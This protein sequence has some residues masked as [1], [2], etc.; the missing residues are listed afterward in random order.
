MIVRSILPLSQG[1]P[2]LALGALVAIWVIARAL[3]WSNPF[4][5]VPGSEAPSQLSADTPDSKAVSDAGAILVPWQTV[6]LSLSSAAP[7]KPVVSS[8]S[9]DLWV[10]HSGDA[11]LTLASVPS[12]IALRHQALWLAALS[13]RWEPAHIA[14]ARAGPPTRAPSGTPQTGSGQRVW[15]SD[16]W[17]FF[18]Q[19]DSS[20]SGL[21][22]ITQTYGASQF[23]GTLRYRPPVGWA[24][25]SDIYFRT[26]RALV[27]PSESQ[28]G[29]GFSTRPIRSLPVRSHLELQVVDQTPSSEVRMAGFATTELPP[30]ELPQR[31]KAE[32]Y[33][34]AGYVTGG[35]ATG[36]V[37]GQAVISRDLAEFSLEN[38]NTGVGAWGGAQR[39]VYR[40]DLGPSAYLTAQLGEAPVRV[41]L[42]WRQR[43]AGDS[44]PPSGFAA[45]IST[46]F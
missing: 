39:G 10:D 45:T 30:I 37:Q 16:A 6:S 21:G 22:P 38:V 18:R 3:I 32:I 41:S 4:L 31:F 35:N 27:E 9:P 17:V 42:D 28:L 33:A 13:T 20:P 25:R 8:E 40:L 1:A 2:I 15:R 19:G 44:M 5:P 7:E 23:G 36:F 46:S 14:L 11:D 29:V 24:D 34:Q 26:Y 12:E 43:V